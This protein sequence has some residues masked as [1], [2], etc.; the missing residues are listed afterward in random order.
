MIFIDLSQED[1]FGFAKRLVGCVAIC[2]RCI[3]RTGE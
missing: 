2:I 1:L 3:D